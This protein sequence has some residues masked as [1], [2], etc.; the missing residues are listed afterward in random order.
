MLEQ[1]RCCAA[2]A[3]RN[4]PHTC[5]AKRR[6]TSRKPAFSTA[7]SS[8]SAI[9]GPKVSFRLV[10]KSAKACL[11]R[12][13]STVQ[14]GAELPAG[15]R[16]AGWSRFRM[17]CAGRATR[18]EWPRCARAFLALVIEIPHVLA[19]RRHQRMRAPRRTA[20]R[21]LV[22]A[23]VH[24][25]SGGVRKHQRAGRVVLVRTGAHQGRDANT[26]WSAS[27][28]RKPSNARCHRHSQCRCRR[29]PVCHL[30]PRLVG[31]GAGR[32]IVRRAAIDAAGV[33][34]SA[35]S[36]RPGPEDLGARR[37]CVVTGTQ[38]L[39]GRNSALML[40]PSGGLRQ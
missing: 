27:R 4:P 14:P 3:W 12:T 18:G 7:I 29:P 16:P 37:R 39:L 22:G 31:V 20:T 33:E 19:A 15:T 2:S 30:Q 25:L 1:P 11:V 23:G 17:K 9:E 28:W 8:P 38:A 26:L 34:A 36:I 6:T 5:Q 32:F 35:F 13:A 21:R 10:A 24:R 40:Q